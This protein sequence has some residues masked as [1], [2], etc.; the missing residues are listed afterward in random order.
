MGERDT[1]LVVDDI[2]V[3]RI[4]LK[5]LFEDKYTILVAEDGI[6]AMDIIKKY[7]E[8]LIAVLLDIVMPRASGYD[9]LKCIKEEK[10][11]GVIPVVLITGDNSTAAAKQGYDLGAEDVITK[12]FD[13]NIVKKRVKNIIELYKHKNNLELLLAEQTYKLQKQTVELKL[14][15]YRTIDALS[16]IV[17]FRNLESGYHIQRIKAFTKVLL[18]YLA[19]NY[20]EYD[21]DEDAIELISQAAAMHDVGKIAIPDNILLKPGRLT[22]G[23]F[24]IMKT[25]TV[26]GCEILNTVSFIS[27]RQYYKYCYDI[28]KS[29]HERYDGG[30]YPDGLVGENIPI[31]AQVVAIADVYDALVSERV[32]KAAYTK[33]EA[34]KMILNG[35]CGAFN[36]KIIE[37]FMLAK[38]D[39]E[40]LADSHKG[41]N[42][43]ETTSSNNSEAANSEEAIAAS[44]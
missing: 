39:F 35:E 10:L 23:E 16:T 13:A 37:C 43:T 22:S 27:D 8:E 11:M 28:C 41:D 1:I 6:E 44:I 2:E 17:E 20:K 7:H 34:Y 15:N 9:V 5:R 26:K 14:N 38:E 30:G 3:N 36:P 25:H 4:L 42:N 33:D 29:H 31:A 12:P 18:R 24:N 21:I 32:Y 19:S 40:R